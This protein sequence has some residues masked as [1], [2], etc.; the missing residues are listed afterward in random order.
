MTF[1]ITFVPG[2]TTGSRHV[3][4]DGYRYCLDK[5]RDEKSYWRCTTKTCAGRLSLVDDT[6]VTSTK[7]HSHPPTP[8]A[9]SV[10]TAKQNMKRKASDTDLPTKHLV[11]D[12][13]GPLSFEALSQ[14][15]CQQA[16]LAKMA[17]TTRTKANRHPVAPRSLEDLVLTPDY[18]RT[19][20]GE[21][22]LLWDSTYSAER[23]RSFLFGTVDNM[24]LL[25]QAPHLVIDGTFSTSPNLFTQMVTIHGLYPDGWRIPLAYGFLPS[26]TQAH[27]EALLDAAFGVD[28]QSVLSDYE[29]AL[30]GCTNPTIWRFIDVLKKEQDLTDWKI[31]QKLMRQPPPPRQKKWLDYD[32]RLNVVIDDYDNYERLDFLKCVGSMILN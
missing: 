4:H 32:R 26:K 30:M 16:S 31:A 23:R 5:K 6:T 25:S 10:H 20:K 12:A 27:Y 8:A 1:T 18:I 11:A 7:P 17:S 3:I 22:F 14:L 15:N 24:D 2:R 29:R 28:P 13:V 9:N 19:N 21:T